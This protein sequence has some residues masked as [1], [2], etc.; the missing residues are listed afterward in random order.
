MEE[1]EKSY[2][3]SAYPRSSSER[4]ERGGTRRRYDSARWL[5]EVVDVRILVVI[6]VVLLTVI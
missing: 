3:T 5:D 2:A 4:H 1:E 6:V